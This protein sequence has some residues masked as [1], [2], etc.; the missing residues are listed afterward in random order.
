MLDELINDSNAAHKN[1][2]AKKNMSY[3]QHPIA[4]KIM[5]GEAQR[6]DSVNIAIPP[7]N[8]STPGVTQT[9]PYPKYP[10]KQH[11]TH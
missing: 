2:F 10:E 9:P 11:H 7:N 8:P 4:H 5:Q 1:Y 6:V 3:Q